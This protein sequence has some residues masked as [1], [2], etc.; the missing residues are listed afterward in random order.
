MMLIYLR[1][2]Q[3]RASGNLYGY[4][5]P[6]RH[7][8]ARIISRESGGLL[9]AGGIRRRISPWST[10]RS[11]MN[12]IS[13]AISITSI[14]E[15]PNHSLQCI[16]RYM[17]ASTIGYLVPYLGVD[18]FPCPTCNGFAEIRS[19][20]KHSLLTIMYSKLQTTRKRIPIACF[21]LYLIGYMTRL[22]GCFY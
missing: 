5:K 1:L 9:S 3:I 21:N 20:G 18:Y 7:I 11:S 19:L 13:N 8:H 4:M 22:H 10:V 16:P 15:L 2:A 14:C 6:Q 12:G 17:H